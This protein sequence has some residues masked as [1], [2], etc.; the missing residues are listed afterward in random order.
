MGRFNTRVKTF[1]GGQITYSFYDAGV[2][3]GESRPPPK[4]NPD[5]TPGSPWLHELKARKRARGEVYDIAKSNEWDWFVTLTLSPERV[6]RW[7]YEACCE[8]LQKFTLILRR[9]GNQYVI[10][11][12]QHKDGAW[13][14]HG[15]IIGDLKLTPAT[16]YWTGE[17]LV[18]KQGRTI[19]N[20]RNY[21]YGLNTATAVG[22]SGKAAN[23]LAKYMLKEMKIPKGKKRYWASKDLKRPEIEYAD[24]S[25]DEQDYV[26][27]QADYSKKIDMKF[28]KLTLCD[29]RSEAERY[30]LA[31]RF[32]VLPLTMMVAPDIIDEDDE[33]NIFVQLDPRFTWKPLEWEQLEIKQNINCCPVL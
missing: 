11:P 21:K 18:D 23:Y 32:G 2:V 26:E 8:E 19:Y 27:D 25:I 1:P 29:Y 17:L 20:I 28:G 10:V 16:N 12:E 30:E 9:A 13:H 15:L 4:L 24:F 3:V 6:N 14:F 33:D 5:H 31:E 22:H 7:D